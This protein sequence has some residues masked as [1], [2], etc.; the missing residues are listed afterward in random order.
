MKIKLVTRYPRVGDVVTKSFEE[1]IPVGANGRTIKRTFS[2]FI[3]KP[4]KLE[5]IDNPV[6]GIW[7]SFEY[8]LNTTNKKL[9]VIGKKRKS[10]IDI[11]EFVEAV[12]EYYT[13][14]LNTKTMG[15]LA[16]KS[17]LKELA[18]LVKEDVIKQKHLISTDIIPEPITNLE[19]VLPEV[20]LEDL[21]EEVAEIKSLE[22]AKESLK[23]TKSKGKK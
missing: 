21:S 6:H 10:D 1:D 23:E 13:M 8:D 22:E 20:D 12:A 18:K 4:T 16:E 19:V 5:R 14:F 11:K 17:V 15:F 3:L 2:E 9:K 7:H